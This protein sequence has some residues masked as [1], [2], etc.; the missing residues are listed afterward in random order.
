M[1]GAFVAGLFYKYSKQV[2]FV[3]IGEVL[4]TSIFGGLAAYIVAGWMGITDVAVTAYIF[5]FF[6][7]RL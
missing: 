1:F 2:S 4:G 3:F 7:Q 5:R 6:S